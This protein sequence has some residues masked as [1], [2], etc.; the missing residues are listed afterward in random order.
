[1]SS[2]SPARPHSG[3]KLLL[4][5]GPLFAFFLVNLK[6]GLLP[7]TGVLVPLSVVALAVSWRLDGRVSPIALYST[8]AV[9]LFGGLSL[10]LRDVTFIKVKLTVI[11]ALFGSVLAIGLVRGKSLLK[12]LLGQDMRLTE[13]GWRILTLRFALFFFGLAGANEVVRRV[14][15]DRAYGSFKFLGVM[16]AMF[17][18]MLAQAPLLKAHALE[19]P[20]E[21]PEA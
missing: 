15:S 2:D 19:D 11:Y 8:V 5:L 1:M 12:E 6:W 4:D 7:A 16:G 18:F 21:D 3:R 10:W 13:A 9:V 20:G 14:V 17:V